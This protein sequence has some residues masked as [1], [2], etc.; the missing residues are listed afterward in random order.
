MGA[1]IP[2]ALTVAPE[3]GRWLFGSGAAKTVDAVGAAVQAVTGTADADAAAATLAG[4]PELAVQLRTQLAQIAAQAEQ[5]QRQSD[6]DTLK[7]QLA[8][9]AGARQQTVSLAQAGS[10][11]AWSPVLLSGIV[12]LAFAAMIYIVLTRSIPDGSGPLANV[13]LGTLAA[14]AAQVGNYWLGSSA[15][16]AAKDVQVQQ[17]AKDARESVPAELAHRLL[18][19][20]ATPVPTGRSADDLNAAELANLAQN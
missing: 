11:I 9:V 1:L 3:I 17:M 13:L 12:L 2:L 15:G 16:S 14:M 6:L 5:A 20:V 7:S 19:P 4:K 10:R 8:D 18:P